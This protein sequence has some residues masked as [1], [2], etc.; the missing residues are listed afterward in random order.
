MVEYG[1]AKAAG[2]RARFEENIQQMQSYLDSN[3][4]VKRKFGPVFEKYF[5]LHRDQDSGVLV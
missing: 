4:N 3:R 2:E 1:A 5:F